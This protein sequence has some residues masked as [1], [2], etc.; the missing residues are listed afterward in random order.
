MD[1]RSELL[2]LINVDPLGLLQIP[3]D[4]QSSN[5]S[6][7]SVLRNNFEDIVSYYEDHGKEPESNL[8]DIYEYQLYCRLKVIRN[9]PEM[10]KY[11]KQFDLYSLLESSREI[12]LEQVISDDPFGLLSDESEEQDIFT[13]KNVKQSERINPE[14]ISRRKKCP[15]FELY[16]PLFDN[17]LEELENG[18]RKLAQ[19]KSSELRENGF[20]VLNGVIVY[21]S[22]VDGS[23]ENYTF[24]S[25][26]RDRYDGRTLCI[27]DN[28]T[29]SDMLFRSLDKALQK[30]GYCISGLISA[31]KTHVEITDED[32]SLGYIYVL[33]SLHP[34]LRGENDIYKIGCT[35]TS[36][37]ERIKNARNE[38]TYLYADVEI[39]ET[40][41]CYNISAHDV[42]QSVHSF[43]DNA[44]LDIDIPDMNG[45]IAKP[46]EW[47]HV[48][49]E[50]IDEIVELL[51][52][53]R[54]SD[55]LF[56][57]RSGRILQR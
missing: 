25:G 12:T 26:N 35:T 23:V 13:L 18:K 14:F 34:R 41:K 1:K 24:E 44:R 5:H 11:L 39:V 15:D 50:I 28:G 43:L 32:R 46:R 21:L 51:Q 4:R 16:K 55:Y 9:S 48:K 8:N 31:E 57:K 45:N 49:L 3:E 20:Y 7:N 47:F 42:E 6:E 33:K 54:I 40:Y 37:S 17:I 52:N 19:Y 56:D 2:G 10:V 27:F 29:C 53:N 22:K 30:D 38:A 36:V